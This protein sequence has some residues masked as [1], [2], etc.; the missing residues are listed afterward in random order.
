MIVASV[1]CTLASAALWTRLAGGDEATAMLVT[2]LTTSTSWLATTA[3]LAWGTG[4]QV[5]INTIEMM[6]GLLLVLV[7]PVGIGQ[8]LRSIGPLARTATRFKRVIGTVSQLLILVIILKA[9]ADVSSRLRRETVTLSIAALLATAGLCVAVHLAALTAGFWG[10]RALGFDR[11]SRIAVAF[12]G[13]QKTLPV[14]LFLFDVYF[15][16]YALAVV[17]MV[18]YHI[19]QLLADTFI[20]DGFARRPPSAA[21]IPTEVTV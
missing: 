12:A 1:P 19:G 4:T 6:T 21:D 8:A 3:W 9:A 15:K 16:D 11:A 5:S 20:A 18:C 10:G 13:S 2:L 17:P 14:G 7:L